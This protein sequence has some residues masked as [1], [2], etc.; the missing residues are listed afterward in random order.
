MYEKAYVYIYIY[1]C[2]IQLKSIQFN[3]F[4]PYAKPSANPSAKPS[5]S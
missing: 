1:T 2:S 4:K 3:R 5:V